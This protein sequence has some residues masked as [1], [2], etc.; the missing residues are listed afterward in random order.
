M[1]LQEYSTEIMRLHIGRRRMIPLIA[2]AVATCSGGQLQAL[3]VT[4]RV[5]REEW[6]EPDITLDH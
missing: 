1:P 4:H 3:K 5:D 2:E 6:P